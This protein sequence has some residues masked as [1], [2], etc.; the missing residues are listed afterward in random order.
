MSKFAFLSIIS[1]LLI[2]GCED[3]NKSADR[4][5]AIMQEITDSKSSGD[6]VLIVSG[7]VIT[8]SDI[9][10]SPVELSGTFVSPAEHF[11][12]LAQTNNLQEFKKLAWPLMEEILMNKISEILLSQEARRQFENNIDEALEK[13]AEKEVRKFFME[14]GGDEG[15]A[16]EKLK[17]MGMD[18][19]KFKE[20]RKNFILTQW[21]IS[22]KLID[23]K[24][25]THSELI[26]CY[27]QMKDQYFATPARLEFQLIDIQPA[28]LEVT[29]PNL[30]KLEQARILANQLI[31]RIEQG[32]DFGELAKQYSHGHTREAGGLW[33]PV[34]PESLAKPY[35]ILAREAEKIEPGQIAGPI[36]VEG[37]IFI[38]KLVDKRPKI[39]EPFEKVQTE[40]EQKIFIDRRQKAL[41]ELDAELL[42]QVDLNEKDKFIDF[43]LE[44]IYQISNQ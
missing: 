43:C 7:E 8:S 4:Q 6:S 1:L 30:D 19:Q 33:K 31:K 14:F 25:V 11:K 28:K 38:M 27:D 39:Y 17:Q 13:A 36:E 37:H 21:Y 18:R 42:Q 40:L 29:D 24:P 9:I 3:S 35:D 26:K 23:E 22:S 2:G 41:E 15:K 32:E 34:Q 10:E 12:D 20:N 5:I 44:K 16:E